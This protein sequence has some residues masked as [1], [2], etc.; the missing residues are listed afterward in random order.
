MT[1]RKNNRILSV[2][3]VILVLCE[4][5]S[6]VVLFSRMSEFSGGEFQN[7]I[8]LTESRGNTKV[9]VL[10]KEK[11][12]TADSGNIVRLANPSYKAYDND[13]VWQAETDV[14]I[15]HLSY[16]NGS[17][18]VTVNGETGNADKLIAP[19]T[20]NRYVFTLENSGDVP[21]D[22]NM[23]MEARIIG[24]DLD[25]PVRA[26]VW[27][28]Q[29]QYLIGD[30]EHK[31]KVMELN[32]VN[33]DGVLGAGRYAVYNLEWEWPFEQGI[34]EYDTML[35]NLA[36]DKDLSLMIK[37]NTTAMYDENPTSPQIAGAGLVNPKT[38]DTT[39]VKLYLIIAGISL[40]IFVICL[41]GG[42]KQDNSE[43]NA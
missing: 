34:D 38:G 7:I 36:V 24:T 32:K 39:P 31:E 16:E 11:H 4:A 8:P 17:G 9:T 10:S 28:Y 33:K 35:G 15:F 18:E 6:L 23:N 41:F 42:K 37:I 12:E 25:I 3:L 2:I 19:G 29:G 20:S 1:L 22:Y 5:A 26:R 27:D 43:D 40:T 30:S 14:E 13:T 21:L